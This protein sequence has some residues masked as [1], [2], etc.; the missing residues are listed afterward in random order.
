MSRFV[1]LCYSFFRV[2]RGELFKQKPHFF[3]YFRCPYRRP[4]TQNCYFDKNCYDLEK[5]I[6]YFLDNHEETR[7]KQMFPQFPVAAGDPLNDYKALFPGECED[8]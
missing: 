5:N 6:C 4:A 3:L 2:Y 7:A 1:N 8:Y